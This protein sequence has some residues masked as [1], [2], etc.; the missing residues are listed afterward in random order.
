MY[1]LV[2][3]QTPPARPILADR[4]HAKRSSLIPLIAA[5]RQ[6]LLLLES[7]L[8]PKYGLTSFFMFQLFYCF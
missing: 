8:R 3:M 1:V 7:I 2:F 5:T 4:S 6:G